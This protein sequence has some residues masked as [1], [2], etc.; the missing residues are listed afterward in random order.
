MR[1]LSSPVGFFIS[2]TRQLLPLRLLRWF[3]SP[4]SCSWTSTSTSTSAHEATCP[5]PI[6][7]VHICRIMSHLHLRQTGIIHEILHVR[8]TPTTTP[9]KLLR[10]LRYPRIAHK[11]AH[12]IRVAHEILR[13]LPHHWV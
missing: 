4:C 13:H 6:L 3:T 5:V 1:M 2:A 11:I 12:H 10:H 9:S 7:A 8:H